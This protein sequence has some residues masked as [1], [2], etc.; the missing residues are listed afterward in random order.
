MEY[1]HKDS[2]SFPNNA[3]PEM[4]ISSL[5]MPSLFHRKQ[6]KRKRKLKEEI[7]FPK[8]SLLRCQPSSI[9]APALFLAK[10]QIQKLA[11][12]QS[13][14]SLS[15]IFVLSSNVSPN[16]L[17]AQANTKNQTTHTIEV[18]NPPTAFPRSNNLRAAD[19]TEL[20]GA[21]QFRA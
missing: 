8:Q 7:T 18:D 14:V 10:T 9:P 6:L 11:H 17:L 4:S 3:V 2:Q 1:I 15:S 20:M 21:C 13:A 5:S 16:F 19:M 12:P